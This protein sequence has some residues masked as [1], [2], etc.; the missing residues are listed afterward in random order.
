MKATFTDATSVNVIVAA[1]ERAGLVRDMKPP[2]Y[3][4]RGEMVAVR[5][6][7]V[8]IPAVNFIEVTGSNHHIMRLI[9]VLADDGQDC[10]LSVI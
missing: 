2:K 6:K 4:H 7:L 10:L 8:G 9:G 1:I 5:N 3:G